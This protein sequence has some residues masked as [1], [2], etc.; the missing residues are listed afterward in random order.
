MKDWDE[1]LKER[2][3][4]ERSPLPDNDWERFRKTILE[5]H[6]RKRRKLTWTV[7][8]TT[9]A[10]ASVV[11]VISIPR[12]RK[13]SQEEYMESSLIVDSSTYD[14]NTLDLEI[15]EIPEVKGVFSKNNGRKEISVSVADPAPVDE[16]T[17]VTEILEDG[18]SESPSPTLPATPVPSR[19]K[20][21]IPSEH[22]DK[23][24]IRVASHLGGASITGSRYSRG[25]AS[26]VGSSPTTVSTSGTSSV[27]EYSHT[28]PI[29]FGLDV[30]YPIN[31]HFLLTSGAEFSYY[32][33]LC[34]SSTNGSETQVAGYLGIPLRIDYSFWNTKNM[35]A[36][37][38]AGGKVDRLVYGRIGSRRVNDNTL[39]WSLVGNMGIQ[40]NLSEGVGLFLAPE[41]SYYFKPAN[42]VL[43]TYRTANPFVFS[44]GAGLRFSL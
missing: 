44:V 1:I 2:F 38:G 32:K 20:R 19:E 21:E 43:Q 4:N 39:N 7:A 18:D 9:M 22:I 17:E 25:N 36:W 13:P 34:N 40:Y 35:S 8:I 3:E 11:A 29:T 23:R 5:P 41:V 30:S 10:A 24:Q 14:I 33:T 16:D 37:V 28:I 31:C 26:G 42:P 27:V 6:L 15:S 12:F